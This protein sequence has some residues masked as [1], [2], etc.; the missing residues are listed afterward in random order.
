MT[1]APADNQAHPWLRVQRVIRALIDGRT[2]VQAFREIE[3]E[4]R[5]ALAVRDH[6]QHA[7]WF[8]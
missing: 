5:Q 3:A 7:G 6:V 8:T 1:P 2:T 4:I